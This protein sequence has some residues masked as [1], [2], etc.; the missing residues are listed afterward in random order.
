[1]SG[2]H[3][4]PNACPDNAA[5]DSD[6]HASDG[7]ANTDTDTGDLHG[8]LRWSNRAGLAEWLGGVESDSRRWRDVG[9]VERDAGQCT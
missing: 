3:A 9:D 2:L 1:M 5:A 7:Y 6:A 8:K 4:D